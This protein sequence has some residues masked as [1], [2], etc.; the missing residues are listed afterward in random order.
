MSDLNPSSLKTGVIGTRPEGQPP[1]TNRSY[2]DLPILK[3]SQWTWMVPVYFVAGGL[4]GGAY[5][6]ARLADRCGGPKLRS[7]SRTATF[8]SVGSLSICPPLLIF[9]LGDPKRFYNMLRIWKPI[10]PMNVGSWT[11]TAFSGAV[12]IALLRELPIGKNRLLRAATAPIDLAGIPLALMMTGYTGVLLSTTSTPIWTQN[13]W[14]GP[15]FTTSAFELACGAMSLCLEVTG[16]LDAASTAAIHP[17]SN[18]ARAATVVSLGG[19]LASAGSSAKSLTHG[20]Y[21]GHIWGGAIACGLV[22]PPILELAAKRQRKRGK[23]RAAR[24]LSVA[25]SVLSLAGGFA[26]KWAITSAGH[27]SGRDPEAARKSS[28]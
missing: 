9:D 8:L 25:A 2:Y 24:K 28:R 15:L 21:A 19:Y 14:L 20:R 13:Q 5:V 16:K 1:D 17:V 4:S 7:L 27:A 6:I 22:L 26:L 18:L 10:S 23:E 12:G 3:A 11:L